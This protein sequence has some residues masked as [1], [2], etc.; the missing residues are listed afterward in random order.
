VPEVNALPASFANAKAAEE[1]LKLLR[2][3]EEAVL[4]ERRANWN[5]ELGG[6]FDVFKPELL[7]DKLTRLFRYSGATLP[8]LDRMHEIQDFINSLIE[9]L[10]QLVSWCDER[11]NDAEDT[12][13]EASKKQSAAMSDQA[14]GWESALSAGAT[15]EARARVNQEFLRDLSKMARDQRTE[16]RSTF[17]PILNSLSSALVAAQAAA[18]GKSIELDEQPSPALRMFSGE[19]I[20]DC[21]RDFLT[22]AAQ[23][24]REAL[25]DGI[26]RNVESNP[27][28]G[29]KPGNFQNVV[30]QCMNRVVDETLK[31]AFRSFEIDGGIDM[32]LLADE[33]EKA[34]PGGLANRTLLLYHGA[35]PALR[36]I[37]QQP[38]GTLVAQGRVGSDPDGPIFKHLQKL[39]A[40][41]QAESDNPREALLMRFV[42]GIP[43]WAVQGLEGWLQSAL[44]VQVAN[45]MPN[46]YLDPAWAAVINPVNP[47]SEKDRED[48][49]LFTYGCALELIQ[50][51]KGRIDLY[52]FVPEHEPRISN[53]G[54]SLFFADFVNWLDASATH[55]KETEQYFEKHWAARAEIHAKEEIYGENHP[56]PR[57]QQE[58]LRL[59]KEHRASLF[60]LQKEILLKCRHNSSKSREAARQDIALVRK[61]IEVMG[62]LIAELEIEDGGEG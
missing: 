23:Q 9:A 44:N 25:L 30:D 16:L 20:A 18:D 7:L 4:K 33:V 50:R 41:I 5:K 31:S 37:S 22:G 43:L 51:V 57:P 46:N 61:E 38:R 47:L 48:H 6:K 8:Q 55:R 36:C 10:G 24:L 19:E 13:L 49:R 34:R 21:L 54:R 14:S 15:Q 62:Y 35:E 11:W 32:N 1:Q 26:L 40:T 29:A 2:A 42:F 45:N 59:F 17:E 60:E 56:R 58:R 28:S 12:K 3:R 27:A 39:D 53:E 52:Y